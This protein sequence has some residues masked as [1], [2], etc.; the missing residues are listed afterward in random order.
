MTYETNFKHDHVGVRNTPSDD[1]SSPT[2]LYI[3]S[4]PFLKG[5]VSLTNEKGTLL[6]PLHY[7]D[8]KN[9]TVNSITRLL[10]MIFIILIYE[11]KSKLHLEIEYFYF[12]QKFYHNSIT[13][14]I[15]YGLNIRFL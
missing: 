13:D 4:Y 2:I 9:I 1:F 14:N 3:S 11:P 5:T 10:E 8:G 12:L 7:Q 6:S 15:I